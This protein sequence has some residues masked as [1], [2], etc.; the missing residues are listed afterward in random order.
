MNY[1]KKYNLIIENRK[2]NP[3][4]GYVERHH[5]IP[6]CL[7]GSDDE[8]NLV[9]LT[10]REHFICHALLAKMYPKESNEWYKMNYALSMMQMKST[11]HQRYFNSH[12][13]SYYRDRFRSY[14]SK[15]MSKRQMGSG[16][17]VYEKIWISNIDLKKTKMINSTSE[18][19][20]GWIKGRN[21]WKLHRSGN[22]KP[23]QAKAERSKL[24]AE[25][26]FK[27]FC[28]NDFKSLNAFAKSDWCD[29]SQPALTKIL[30]KYVPE[31]N[32]SQGKSFKLR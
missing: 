27:L 18:I 31:Y 16:N 19:P 17:S 11:T 15:D 1:S 23:G 13:Y 2:R 6:R 24:K 25:R 22:R 5:I 20:E 21:K 30:K 12:L 28:E 29:I 8:S 7:G 9:A 26:L 14:I 10:A 3:Y 4:N 32:T